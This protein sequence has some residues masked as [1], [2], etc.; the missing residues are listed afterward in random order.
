M[1]KQRRYPPEFRRRVLELIRSGQSIHAT[2]LK[3]DISRQ[4]VMNWL[5]Q[6]DLDS[7]RSS[8]GATTAESQEVAR[9]KRRVRELE[10][11]REILSKA[12]AWFARE[13]NAVPKKSSDS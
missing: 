7:G 2:A 12:A 9:L 11:E 8:D 5:R 6:D 4:T 10:L 3:F 1:A 13:T